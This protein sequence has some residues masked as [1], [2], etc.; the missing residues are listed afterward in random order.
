MEFRVRCSF[1]D[2]EIGDLYLF[3][4]DNHNANVRK[5]PKIS[6][7]WSPN[8]EVRASPSNGQMEGKIWVH[9]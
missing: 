9:H 7:S 1:V 6:A 3:G 8:I 2:V 4:V 5:Q